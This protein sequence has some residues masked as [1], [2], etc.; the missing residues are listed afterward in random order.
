MEH[1]WCGPIHP[2]ILCRFQILALRKA[3]SQEEYRSAIQAL[4]REY[5][6]DFVTRCIIGDPEGVSFV[7][8]IE[9]LHGIPDFLILS[10]I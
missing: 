8:E 5:R 7:L 9:N 3:H 2:I 1:L 10:N 4:I 6:T